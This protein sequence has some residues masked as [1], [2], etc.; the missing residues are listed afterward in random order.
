MSFYELSAFHLCADNTLIQG[1]VKGCDIVH[2]FNIYKFRTHDINVSQC[3]ACLAK[4][5]YM[6]LEFILQH[7]GP[8]YPFTLHRFAIETV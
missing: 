5:G 4:M 8:Q 6:K 7:T 3:M 1:S 2:P